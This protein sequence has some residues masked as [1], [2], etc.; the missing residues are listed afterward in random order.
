MKMEIYS[1]E[2]VLAQR[3]FFPSSPY[4]SGIL[5]KY[6]DKYTQGIE[7]ERKSEINLTVHHCSR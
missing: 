3:L 7:S 4:N 6:V 2:T 1:D 5:G